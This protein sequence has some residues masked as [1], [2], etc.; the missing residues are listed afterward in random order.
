M[1]AYEGG[2]RRVPPVL[3]VEVAG[4]DEGDSESALRKKA[5]WYLGV[6]VSVV[7]IVLP[8]SQEVL[9]VSEDGE[10]RLSTRKRIEAHPA[11]PGLSPK[12]SDLY[13]QVRSRR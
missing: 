10:K 11:L 2:L 9:V 7:W 8:R 5:E 4:L 13:V 12:V 6:G 3:A 1:G